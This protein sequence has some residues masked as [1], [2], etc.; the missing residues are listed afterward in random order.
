M[1]SSAFSRIFTIACVLWISTLAVP[2]VFASVSTD[3]MVGY[4]KFDEGS[5][6]LA[7]DSSGHSSTGELLN[8]MSST[9]WVTT[10]PGSISFS[11]PYALDFDGADDHI[12]FS[13]GADDLYKFGS[14]VDMTVSA[15]IKTSDTRGSY[16]P[17]IISNENPTARDGFTLGFTSSTGFPFFTSRLTCCPAAVATTVINDGEWH[18]I[19]GARRGSTGEIYINGTREGTVSGANV[20]FATAQELHIGVDSGANWY[21]D[22]LIDEVRLY[23]R[24]LTGS[25]ITSLAAGNHTTA[26]WTN[27][28]R[29]TYGGGGYG[30]TDWENTENWDISAVPDPFTHIIIQDVGGTNRDPQLTTAISGAS[31]TIEASAILDA[32]GFNIDFTSGSIM[33]GGSLLLLNSETLTNFTPSTT[34]TGTVLYYGTGTYTELVGG[35]DYYNLSIN[36]G[37]T[38][39][40]KFDEGTGTTAYDASGYG[41]DGTLTNGPLWSTTTPDAIDFTNPYAI[42]FDG[43]N[44]FVDL[45]HYPK[46]TEDDEYYTISLWVKTTAT[47]GYILHR[48]DGGNCI[49]NP[50]ITVDEIRESGCGSVN[51]VT[52]TGLNDGS[53]HNIIALRNNTFVAVYIDGTLHN[54]KTFTVGTTYKQEYDHFAIGARVSGNASATPTGTYFDGLIDDVRVYNRP[55]M[56]Q[57]ITR[58]ASGGQPQTASG[59]YIIDAALDIAGSLILA[60]GD[61]DVSSSAFNINIDNSWQNYGG[62]FTAQSGSVIIDG[63][64]GTIQSGGQSFETLSINDGLIGYWKFDEGSGETAYDS[65]GY[66]RSGT[67]NGGQSSTGWITNTQT[68]DFSNPYALEFDGADDY[69]D[70]DVK[71]VPDGAKTLAL[72]ARFPEGITSDTYMIADEHDT[73]NQQKFQFYFNDGDALAFYNRNF[74][75]LEYF[76]DLS[77]ATWHHVAYAYADEMQYLYLDGTLVKS[78]AG[79]DLSR[80]STD[81]IGS[82]KAGGTLGYMNG[83]LDDVRIY[84]RALSATEISTLAGGSN[85]TRNEGTYTLTD[86]LDIEESLILASQSLDVSTSNFAVTASGSFLS[87][88]GV[89]TPREGTVTLDG[90]DDGFST[91]GGTFYNLTINSSSGATVVGPATV[92]NALSIN[93]PLDV[94]AANLTVPVTATIT[95]ASTFSEGTG[96]IIHPA[97]G[98]ITDGTLGDTFTITITDSDENVDPAAVETVTVAI[99]SETVTLTETG[100]NTGTFSGTIASTCGDTIVGNG[101]IERSGHDWYTVYV[102]WVDAE[103][104]TDTNSTIATSTIANG[105]CDGV[106]ATVSSGGGGGTTRKVSNGTIIGDA[107]TKRYTSP[108]PTIQP[109]THAAAPASITLRDVPSGEWYEGAVTNLVSKGILSGYKDQNGQPLGIFRPAREISH[110][111]ALKLVLLVSDKPE[112]QTPDTEHWAA[113]YYEYA[114]KINTPSLFRKSQFDTPITRADCIALLI[115]VGEFSHASTGNS[116]NDVPSNHPH[117][118]AISF[119]QQLGWI[120]GDTDKEGNLL[121]RFRPDAELSRAEFSVILQRVLE[122]SGN[123]E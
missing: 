100:V 24:A 61:L 65:S 123:E 52:H 55:L 49:Y 75:V 79:A 95:N 121:H 90:I 82:R 30:D 63:T 20:S 115:E 70:L 50:S 48:G 9:G 116:F 76:T 12:T 92:S 10:I 91:E 32:H 46:H 21:F 59:D 39:Y 17:S 96:A 8:G 111:E 1:S 38:T 118:Q 109:V 72:W 41:R 22:G 86:T 13:E 58:L 122:Q 66:G 33:G 88:G 112:L 16:Y 108:T 43:T 110:A 47:T 11:D 84:D 98:T 81:R 23:N 85:F 68:L 101:V 25:E 29:N 74:G 54:S 34:S 28:S 57:E 64:T 2:Q 62:T 94:T 71:I 97:T 14:G 4:W 60:G 99:L 56:A 67:L 73:F 3:A 105:S 93:N 27:N 42:D 19:V 102:S 5:G 77:D 53:W 114:Q 119:A 15:W 7:A 89:F 80:T 83:D 6:T 78:G 45:G 69:V 104:S 106:A 117:A 44:D 37:L 26:I 31:I 18:H 103:D 35:D 113:P 36:D 107:L 40:L 120:N 87:Y 51:Q